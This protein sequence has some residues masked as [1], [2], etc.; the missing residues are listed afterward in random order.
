MYDGAWL[1]LGVNGNRWT[2]PGRCWEP[3]MDAAA[4]G[5]RAD[6]HSAGRGHVLSQGCNEG[7]DASNCDT[8]EYYIFAK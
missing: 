4:P 1:V 8:D 3:H 2:D 5:E 6:G 7:T